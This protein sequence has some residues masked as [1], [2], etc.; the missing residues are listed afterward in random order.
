MAFHDHA[1]PPL[2]ASVTFLLVGGDSHPNDGPIRICGGGGELNS[3]LRYLEEKK[4]DCQN[5]IGFLRLGIC[6]SVSACTILAIVFFYLYFGP[7]TPREKCRA[8][9]LGSVLS[10]WK[11]EKKS[12]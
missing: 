10:T 2:S 8:Q 11:R 3:K 1:Y 7:P 12:A 9:L 4:F 6:P 5:D